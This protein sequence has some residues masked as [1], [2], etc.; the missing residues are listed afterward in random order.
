[1]SRWMAKNTPAPSATIALN[2]IKVDIHRFGLDVDGTT[3]SGQ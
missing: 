2:T 3:V 1:M